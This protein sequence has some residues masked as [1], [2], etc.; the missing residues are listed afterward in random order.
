MKRILTGALAALFSAL[1]FGATLSPVQLLNPAGSSAGQAIVSTGPTTAP[2]WGG[3]P[4]SGVTGTLA[5]NHGGTGASSA[6]GTALDNITG[7]ASTGFVKRTGAGAYSFIADPLPIANGGTGQTSASAAL[8]ALGGAPLA[9]PTFTGTVTTAALSVTTIAASSTITPSQTA[10]IVGTTTNNSANAG[11]V[12][13]YVSATVG[14]GS[15]VAATTAVAVNVT[16]I[17]LTAGD[18][19][20]SGLVG[21]VPAGSTVVQSVQ[22][23]ISTTSATQPSLALGGGFLMPGLAQAG[24][25]VAGAIA[26]FRESLSGTT[27]VYL[28]CTTGFTVS[29]NGCYGTIRARRIR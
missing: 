10:G 9:S 1:T 21:V 8:S 4:L 2:L 28:V 14:S 22:G 6:S 29:T 25:G 7:F 20:V 16:S 13:E 18:W 19:D 5:V 12:G 27:T 24:T 11:S 17:S 26:P 23:G 15:P 3:V